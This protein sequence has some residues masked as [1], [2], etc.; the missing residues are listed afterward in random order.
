MERER[1]GWDSG[2]GLVCVGCTLNHLSDNVC[3]VW[4]FYIEK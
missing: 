3:K 4:H 2:L 1:E